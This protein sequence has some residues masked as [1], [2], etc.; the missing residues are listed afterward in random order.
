MSS[1]CEQW[2][3]EDFI[4]MNDVDMDKLLAFYKLGT[5]P[6]LEQ[7]RSGAESDVLYEFDGSF[8]WL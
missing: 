1:V 2:S 7:I 3:L 5:I 8:G 6:S 4:D